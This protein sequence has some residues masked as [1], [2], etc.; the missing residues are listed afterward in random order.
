M[1]STIISLYHENRWE[2]NLLPTGLTLF[3]LNGFHHEIKKVKYCSRS[4]ASA[5]AAP[6]ERIVPE[7]KE[8][9]V[10]TAEAAQESG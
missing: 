4:P 2:S 7:R 10:P 3:S 6:T 5:A 1:I 9:A 8:K